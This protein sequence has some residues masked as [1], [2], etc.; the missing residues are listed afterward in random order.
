MGAYALD[1]SIALSDM[2]LREFIMV[3]CR[4][5]GRYFNIANRSDF[6]HDFLRSLYEVKSEYPSFY[7]NKVAFL[8]YY[9]EKF[10]NLPD[11]KTNDESKEDKYVYYYDEKSN[12]LC[13][14]TIREII[15]FMYNDENQF[16]FSIRSL[17]YS[18]SMA[19]MF[20]NYIEK[21]DV[22]D[23][24]LRLSAIDFSVYRGDEKIELITEPRLK[25]IIDDSVSNKE[26]FGIDKPQNKIS[27]KR[28]SKS[29]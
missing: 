23:I 11:R 7:E 19:I 26:M 28:K 6:Y 22:I 2:L 25:G 16:E 10:G 27:L 1:H 8:K 29:K 20:K 17:N 3:V 9:M 12:T 18:A 4:N 14:T 13:S 21:N 15:M 5:S 24:L